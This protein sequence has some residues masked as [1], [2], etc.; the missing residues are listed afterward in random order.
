MSGKA[1]RETLAALGVIAS[2]VFV[3][4]EIRQNTQ[5]ARIAAR[6][7]LMDHQLTLTQSVLE[8][9]GLFAEMREWIETEPGTAPDLCPGARICTL[10]RRQLRFHENVFLQTQEGLI[11]ESSFRSYSFEGQALYASPH[12]RSVWTSLR[13]LLH[14][15]FVV[16]F[17]A[18]YDLA[19]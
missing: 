12:L 4:V 6:Q 15:D 17:E 5:T 7:A 10:V 9:E 18:E 8:D 11:D 19:P 16:A 1:V 14:P 2:L 13:D 3:G